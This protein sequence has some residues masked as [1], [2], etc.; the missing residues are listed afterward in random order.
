M[1]HLQLFFEILKE[2]ME[3]WATVGLV[4]WMTQFRCVFTW[5][6]RGRRRPRSAGM[7][8]VE[9]S[10]ESEESASVGV[11][12]RMIHRTSMG[13][14]LEKRTPPGCRAAFGR[15][16]QARGRCCS[17]HDLFLYEG[18]RVEAEGCRACVV[19]GYG[20]GRV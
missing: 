9:G 20:C 3:A 14:F 12:M 7:E 19:I 16:L 15:E 11:C 13:S 6:S 2:D 10:G 5:V 8:K 4:R 18:G 17:R 1:F